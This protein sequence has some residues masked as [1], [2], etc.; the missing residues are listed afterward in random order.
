MCPLYTLLSTLASNCRDDGVGLAA[1]Q[2]G[3]NVRLMVYN[4]E[5]EKGKGK[6][7]ILV[8]PRIISRGKGLETMGEGCLSFQDYSINLQISGEIEVGFTSFAHVQVVLYIHDT[9]WIQCNS[10]RHA[11]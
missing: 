2:V 7:W 1:P 8:N 9:C 11:V 6:E 3:V 5:G 10:S 4:P